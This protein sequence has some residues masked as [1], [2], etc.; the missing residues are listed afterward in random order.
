MCSF[1]PFLL[2]FHLPDLFLKE[3]VTTETIAIIILIANIL[4]KYFI[5]A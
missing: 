2:D 3:L 4:S 1:I 5:F